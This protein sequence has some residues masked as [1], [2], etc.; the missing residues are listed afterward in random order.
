MTRAGVFS[1]HLE[2]LSPA[3]L[4]NAKRAAAI[5]AMRIIVGLVA[6]LVAGLVYEL[7][8]GLV[9]G[10]GGGLGG[11]AV[12]GLIVGAILGLV[13]GQ[14]GW[15]FG[16]EL[17]GGGPGGS[18]IEQADPVD[19]MDWSWD[20]MWLGLFCGLFCGLLAGLVAWPEVRPPAWMGGGGL[21]DGLVVGLGVAVVVGL[22]FGL[23]TSSVQKRTNVNSGLKRSAIYA[24]A[25]ASPLLLVMPLLTRL[26]ASFGVRDAIADAAVFLSVGASG[27]LLEKGGKF[28]IKN[29]TRGYLLAQAK[30]IPWRYE[31]F[32]YFSVERVLMIR[33][34]GS[35]RFIHRMLQEHL[36][37]TMSSAQ[38]EFQVKSTTSR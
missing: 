1:F 38:R 31:R 18:S 13:Y 15:L 10:L 28:C 24:G 4:P 14:G 16:G 22:G 6:G 19:A 32:L 17:F 20:R 21:V 29:L 8:F 30:Y 25:M 34:G 26:I 12:A 37:A 7:V 2:D 35:V 33:Q 23:V 3:W 9:G 5:R 36:A 27:L 11:G